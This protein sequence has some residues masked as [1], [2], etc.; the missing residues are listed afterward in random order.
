MQGPG[1]GTRVCRPQELSRRPA[2]SAPSRLGEQF[3]WGLILAINPWLLQ[4]SVSLLR[5]RQLA[6]TPHGG[7]GA[8]LLTPT[9]GLWG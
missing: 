3:S 6:P 8:W 7:L 9:E 2:P 1:V 5:P 4:A